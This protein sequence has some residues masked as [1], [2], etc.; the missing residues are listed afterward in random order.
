MIDWILR[1]LLKNYLCCLQ[2]EAFMNLNNL[3]H[4]KQ[5]KKYICAKC[6]KDLDE[7]A[8]IWI[9]NHRFCFDCANIKTVAGKNEQNTV[10][11]DDVKRICH[12]CFK[13][14]SKFESRL[15]NGQ[16]YCL[17]CFKAHSA[18][19]EKIAEAEQKEKQERIK[20]N[21]IKS[22]F[23]YLAKDKIEDY[24][25][26]ENEVQRHNNLRNSKGI[27]WSEH[28]KEYNIQEMILVKSTPDHEYPNDSNWDWDTFVGVYYNES[29]D[30]YKFTI[31]EDFNSCWDG[32]PVF[33]G[34]EITLELFEEYMKIIDNHKYD[35]LIQ[36]LKYKN[37]E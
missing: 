14:V 18:S 9:G 11:T 20:E 1:Y 4:K 36:K 7:N 29:I 33:M 3:F 28:F 12:V 16:Y 8:F 22:T 37:N 27:K 32:V 21:A 19:S 31:T 2:V 17:D 6:K 34:G 26:W 15:F 10:A 25:F 13:S 5:I 30:D 24:I 23:H 35:H